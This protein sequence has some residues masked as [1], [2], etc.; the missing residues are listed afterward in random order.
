[1]QQILA[2]IAASEAGTKAV[3][4]GVGRNVAR[5]E[6]TVGAVVGT[7]QTLT[8]QCERQGKAWLTCNRSLPK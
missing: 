3:I 8:S 4:S 7:V 2:A 1:M 5:L 6:Q